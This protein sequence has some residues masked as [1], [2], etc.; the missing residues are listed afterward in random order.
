MEEGKGKKK[1]ERKT[2]RKKRKKKG[3]VE[4]G[5][6]SNDHLTSS[7]EGEGM[8]VYLP[9]GKRSPLIQPLLLST[10]FIYAGERRKEEGE[11]KI[12]P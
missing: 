6:K 5:G 1:K 12:R 3:R 9:K 4:E 2:S 11:R 7:R 8:E 10:F